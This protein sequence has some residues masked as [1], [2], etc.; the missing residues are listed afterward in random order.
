[1]KKLGILLIIIGIS[2]LAFVGIEQYMAYKE[3]EA[4][5]ETVVKSQ[6]KRD[7][8]ENIKDQNSIQYN[9]KNPV[10]ILEIPKINLVV[11][12][13]EGATQETLKNAVGHIEGTGRLGEIN[14]NYCI[15]G[16]RSHTTGRFFNRLDEVEI[17]DQFT[18][19]TK[20][21]QFI[22]TVVNKMVVTPDKVEVLNPIEGKSLATLITCH[23]LYSNRQRLIVV[24]ELKK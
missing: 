2:I 1:M 20:D 11:P 15:A 24:G 6:E 4:L 16:H 7:Y 22:F 23:P 9:A 12:I 10:G 5:I 18:I 19:K 3:R 13:V 21:K 17:G 14:N 8:K